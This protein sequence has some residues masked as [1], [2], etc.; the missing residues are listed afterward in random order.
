[1][2]F[3]TLGKIFDRLISESIR[4][5]CTGTNPTTSELFNGMLIFQYNL[6]NLFIHNLTPSCHVTRHVT[7]CTW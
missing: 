3:M 2:V 6:Y 4:I 1:M 5:S 7:T